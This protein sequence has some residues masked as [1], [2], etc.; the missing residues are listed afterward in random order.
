MILGDF[1]FNISSGASAPSPHCLQLMDWIT[2]YYLCLLNL[3]NPTRRSLRLNFIKLILL[4][5]LLN[6]TIDLAILFTRNPKTPTI[7]QLHSFPPIPCLNVS[8]S[9]AATVESCKCYFQQILVDPILL[10]SNFREYVY[11]YHSEYIC[12]D[13][14]HCYLL[15]PLVGH[16]I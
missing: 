3:D 9:C 14:V 11:P 1:N 10:L 4:S 7:I 16:N 12:Q 8:Q 13:S 6:F 5:S 15:L 2:T